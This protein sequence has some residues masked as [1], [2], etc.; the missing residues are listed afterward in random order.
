M[1]S[2]ELVLKILISSTIGYLVL[3]SIFK[4]HVYNDLLTAGLIG[5]LLIEMIFYS[6]SP[7]HVSFLVIAIIL[8]IFYL[9]VCIYFKYVKIKYFWL[10]NV[11]KSEYS[12]IKQ[13]LISQEI[14]QDNFSYN[15]KT[16]FLLKFSNLDSKAIRKI[17]KDLE[18]QENKTKK[19][20][21][22]CNYWQIIFFLTIMVLLW[23]F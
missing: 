11:N 13:F 22:I 3:N 5:A 6:D 15:R 1:I 23:R 10:L 20:F 16:P 4:Y 14:K 9:G 7:Y 18:K 17:M 19:H 2:F 8:I 21:T 12:R